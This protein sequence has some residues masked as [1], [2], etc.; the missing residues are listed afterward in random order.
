M[1]R[2]PRADDPDAVAS[3]RV[4]HEQD[5]VPCGPANRDRP[6]FRLGVIWILERQCLGIAKRTRPPRRRRGASARWPRPLPLCRIAA[7]VKGGEDHDDIVLDAEVQ[8]V[9]KR[10]SS[11]RRMPDSTSWYLKGSSAIRSYVAPSSWRNSSPSPAR[12]FS[13]P[14]VWPQRRGRLADLQTS[15]YAVTDRDSPGA[16]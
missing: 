15:R 9:G 10:R 5:L 6:S 11:A 14:G 7:H 16:G 8:S 4:R 12:S 1:S 13:C 2:P 3:L